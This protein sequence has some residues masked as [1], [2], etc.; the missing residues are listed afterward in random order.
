MGVVSGARAFTCSLCNLMVRHVDEDSAV[1]EDGPAL[2]GEE[3]VCE[4][5]ISVALPAGPSPVR[6]PPILQY[7]PEDAYNL[8]IKLPGS[9]P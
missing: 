8:G 2:N 7:I 4:E 1:W 3:D 5:N 9:P 6:L